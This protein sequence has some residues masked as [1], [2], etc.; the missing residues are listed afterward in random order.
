[1]HIELGNV[2][3][4]PDINEKIDNYLG[5]IVDNCNQM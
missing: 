4:I 2:N 1:M 3:D 5:L